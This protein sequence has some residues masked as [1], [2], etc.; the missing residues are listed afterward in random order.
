[1]IPKIIP[2]TGDI[3][4]NAS[5]FNNGFIIMYLALY[6]KPT[7]T[8]PRVIVCVFESG[9]LKI[10]ANSTSNVDV[11]IAIKEVEYLMEYI[12]K[13]I[14]FKTPSL[15]KYA[16]NAVP[17]IIKV[18]LNVENPLMFKMSPSVFSPRVN[19]EKN[20]TIRSNILT[21]LVKFQMFWNE[22]F[23]YKYPNN[24]DKSIA[25]S[26]AIIQKITIFNAIKTLLKLS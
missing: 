4:Q 11:V 12:S 16:P 22:I 2:I 10:V 6:D 26:G 17:I 8:I 18:M 1:M 25:D 9:M 19:A 20:E 15:R 23:V 5:I 13:L 21:A 3:I 7:P 14:L 24:S